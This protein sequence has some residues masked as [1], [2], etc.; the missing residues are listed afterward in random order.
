MNTQSTFFKLS[1]AMLKQTKKEAILK[2]A[3]K[4]F[5]K[6]GF[7]DTS[8]HDISQATGVADGTIFYHFNSKEDLFLAVLKKFK[9]EL[10]SSFTQYLEQNEFQTG[11]EMVEGA[12]S[13]YLAQ[14]RRMEERFLL[15]HR[16][17]YYQIAEDNNN[18]WQQLEEIYSNLIS[19]FEQAIIRGQHDKSIR[20]VD[21]HKKAMLIF[22]MVDGLERLH[23]Y[24]LYQA[25]ALHSELIESCRGMLQSTT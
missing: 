19:L 10:L 1:S 15:L 12:I 24:K 4:L 17:H 13:F 11:L 22:L 18:C 9:E 25:D 16:H 6:N 7:W 8:I 5:S 2:E 21:A 23:T 14:T 20:K 3:T